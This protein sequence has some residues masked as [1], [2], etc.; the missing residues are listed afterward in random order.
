MTDII[1]TDRIA[2]VHTRIDNAFEQAYL[3]ARTIEQRV[4]TDEQ[5]ALLPEIPADHVHYKEWQMRRKSA[6]RL[7]DH[8]KAKDHPL[9]ILEVGCGNGWLS[10]KL[11]DI[12][13]VTVT[14]IDINKIELQQAA[15]VFG[16][17]TNL[18]FECGDLRGDQFSERKYD[19]IVFAA[20][21]QYFQSLPEILD[22]A[23]GL[24][25]IT[26]EVHILDTAFYKEEEVELAQ[27]R[28]VD[29]YE[30]MGCPEMSLRYFHHSCSGLHTFDY[31]ILYDP[32]AMVNKMLN[33]GPFY[34]LCITPDF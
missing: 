29:Y 23:L 31:S 1:S 5:L 30:E 18:S 25:K 17:N 22:R 28:S 15:N 7:I 20:S 19:I 2:N 24:V 4:Y 13:E 6:D 9:S 32:T 27:K 11:A 8:L 21:L 3:K 26:G 16:G 34:W 10:S 12:P 14:G 33:R